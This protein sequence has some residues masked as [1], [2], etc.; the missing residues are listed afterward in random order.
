M[1]IVEN[2]TP[3]RVIPWLELNRV[4]TARERSCARQTVP[5]LTGAALMAH[6]FNRVATINGG[7]R[8]SELT[9]DGAPI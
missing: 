3:M 9:I 7:A 2:N 1:K 8:Y 5:L 6:P 4:A